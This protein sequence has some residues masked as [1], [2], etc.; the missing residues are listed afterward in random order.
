MGAYDRGYLFS[1]L[2]LRGVIDHQREQIAKEVEGLEPSR[3]LN[4]SE[5]DL[6]RYFAEKYTLETPVL[7]RDEM[8]ADQRETQV[9][10]RHHGDRWIRDSSRP[11]YIPGQQIDI[12]I[13]FTGEGDLFKARASTY[14]SAPPRGQIAGQS[15]VLSF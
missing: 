12:E 4:M 3:L 6:L 10:A 11:F 13:P 9:D 8:T 7:L 2:D 1:D 5:E 14:T 15:L